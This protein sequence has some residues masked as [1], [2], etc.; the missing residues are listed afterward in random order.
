M[1]NAHVAD[2]ERLDQATSLLMA[3]L[4]ESRALN[5]EISQAL[6]NRDEVRRTE[7]KEASD[8]PGATVF[9]ILRDIID[10]DSRR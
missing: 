2:R 6:R 10:G 4:Q 1:E 3:S 7:A 8:Q 5:L 9:R